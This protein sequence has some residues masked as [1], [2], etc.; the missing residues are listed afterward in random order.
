MGVIY[1]VEPLDDEIADYLHDVGVIVPEWKGLCRNPTPKEIREVCGNLT[2]L[3]VQYFSPPEHHWQVMIEGKNNPENEPWTLLNVRNF[4]G[5]E[6]EPH[7]ISFEK[8][9]PSLILRIVLGLSAKC[10]PLV[11]VPD[12]GDAPLAVS[13]VDSVENLLTIW[14]HTQ[15]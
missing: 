8:G 11:V 6:D 12:T 13:P 2:D 3:S 14:E 15:M 5:C 4:N 7:A 1:I 9:W 10:G